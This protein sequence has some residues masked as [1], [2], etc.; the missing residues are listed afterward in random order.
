MLD[1][2]LWIDAVKH[3]LNESKTEFIYFGERQ[4]LAKMHKDTININREIINCTNKIKYLGGHH[5]SS[6]TFRY[7]IIA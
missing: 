6:L 3:K 7:H 2:K 4:Q 1:I 5:D